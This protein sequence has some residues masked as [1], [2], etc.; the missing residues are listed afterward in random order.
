MSV[1]IENKQIAK[2]ALKVF[3]GKPKV[4]KYWDDN[5]ASSID[6]LFSKDTQFDDDVFAF[7]TLGLSDFSI[8]F[9][10]NEL[11]L[12]VELVGASDFECFPNL[13]SS[14]AFYIINSNYKCFPGAIFENVV[15]M[16][17]PYSDMKHILFVNPYL[18]ENILETLNFEKKKVTWLM[19]VP[20]SEVEKNFAEEYGVEALE[21]LFEE[22]Q[23]NIFNLERNSS[24]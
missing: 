16:Y 1:S 6:I 12:R 14:C 13:L 5:K 22:K 24:I 21:T 23:I 4:N 9:E 8:G 20:I 7:A 15:S 18:W 3:G 19:I 11:P 17:L 10:N 2:F